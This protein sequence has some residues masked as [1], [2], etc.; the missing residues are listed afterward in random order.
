MDLI[1][2][3]LWGPWNWRWDVGL[4]LGGLGLAYVVGWV[5]LRRRGYDRLARPKPL[6]CYWVGLFTIAV[7]L[8]SPVDTLQ[9]LLFFVHMFQHQLLIYLAPPLLLVGMPLPF[10]LW[11]LPA[12]ARMAVAT[13]LRP[14][15][16]LRRGLAWLTR[17]A[18]AFV[19]STVILWLWHIPAAYNLVLVNGFVHDIQHLTFFG[20]FL[21]YWWAVIGSPPQT[22]HIT[23][24]GGRGLYLALGALQ[25]G[26]LGGL[27]TFADRVLY[28]NYLLVPRLGGLSALSD[29][30]ISGALMWFPG[31]LIFGLAAALL[32]REE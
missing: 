7:A 8:M 20:A 22:A 27:I 32:M 21:L 29:Q 5:R 6:V 15:G 25:S 10:V 1:G 4:L 18:V 19:L 12:G 17:P 11:G 16:L 14:T 30:Q 31:P 9:A 3:M 26:L 13:F 24:N 23:S 28:T 2:R